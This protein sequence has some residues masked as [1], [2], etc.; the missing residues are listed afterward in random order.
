[1]KKQQ[2]D[3]RRYAQQFLNLF[4]NLKYKSIFVDL[5]RNFGVTHNQ[6]GIS[7]LETF[8]ISLIVAKHL[9]PN[10]KVFK[11]KENILEKDMV[12]HILKLEAIVKEF[13]KREI[14]K[15]RVVTQSYSQLIPKLEYFKS[16]KLKKTSP[17]NYFIEEFFNKPPSHLF[18]DNFKA[19]VNEILKQLFVGYDMHNYS[20]GNLIRGFI[21]KNSRKVLSIDSSY[22]LSLHDKTKELYA[23]QGYS[24]NYPTTLLAYMAYFGKINIRW[25]DLYQKN[26][27]FEINEKYDFIYS[28]IDRNDFVYV[29]MNNGYY[30]VFDGKGKDFFSD[31][32]AQAHKS[33][34]EDGHAIF[35]IE[36]KFLFESVSKV[37]KIVDMSFLSGAISLK[38]FTLLL[39]EKKSKSVKIF[40]GSDYISE[41]IE[42]GGHG[43][44]SS[45]GETKKVVNYKNLIKDF[46]KPK[47]KNLK[48]VSVKDLKSPEFDYSIQPSVIFSVSPPGTPLSGCAEILKSKNYSYDE[49]TNKDRIIKVR[50]LS[51][52]AS[53]L[54]VDDAHE[55]KSTLTV[56]KYQKIN[57]SALLLAK[58]GNKLKPTIF[59]FEKQPI[60]IHQN[61]VALVPDREKT[62][63]AYLVM[64]I[65]DAEKS[66][67]FVNFY[68]GSTIP[69]LT[70]ADVLHKIK[71]DLPNL[72]RQKIELEKQLL[73]KIQSLKDQREK[74]KFRA[75]EELLE[76]F[77]DID[78][79][80][81]NDLK[82]IKSSTNKIQNFFNENSPLEKKVNSSW[83]KY[84]NKKEEISIP[85]NN[86]K[87]NIEKAT[88][89]LTIIRDKKSF[90]NT[91]DYPVEDITIYK[92]LTHFR[93][94]VI[95]RNHSDYF[96]KLY[97]NK[98]EYKDVDSSL[99]EKNIAI[100]A[101]IDQLDYMIEEL[102]K[103]AE[104]Y[105]GFSHSKKGIIAM[106]F[107]F[108]QDKNS[109][110]KLVFE[111]NGKPFDE[112]FDT[113]EAFAK[114]KNTSNKKTSHGYGGSMV[115]S[116]AQ[117]YGIES[118]LESNRNN[119]FPVKFIFKF[120]IHQLD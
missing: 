59:E 25:T 119:E 56:N 46:K 29:D 45:P 36:N 67:N 26:G 102:I 58:V 109:K 3:I 118:S 108:H 64:S 21:K 10:S 98:E 91:E 69:Y 100:R 72:S 76:A 11:T 31:T 44:D 95:S 65:S 16:S 105:A 50:D 116:I 106:R 78:H 85:L 120:Q 101:N 5:D 20:V 103:N 63:I 35:F 2:Q 115:E 14:F 54:I 37:K 47:H 97:Y 12:T 9:N 61:V 107:L 77:E 82:R 39:L 1:M 52:D 71:I 79:R 38:N 88:K 53:R 17:T 80:I 104:K 30:G 13:F 6:Y 68:R 24:P 112:G 19:F 93:E 86:I 117:R 4:K 28:R 74:D 70:H 114:N 48:I 15:N 41:F 32:I 75:D 22:V 34:N 90:L 7:L 55:N 111:N 87:N 73:D 96:L 49:I 81:K 40:D 66:G 84:Y 43:N 57:Q 51:K 27:A 33:L 42:I 89:L 110:L 99:A 94:K 92:L 8:C 83:A 113:M 23:G 18:E 60:Y 62:S